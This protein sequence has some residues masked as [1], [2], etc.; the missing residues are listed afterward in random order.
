MRAHT[1]E[2]SALSGMI[3]S[4]IIGG[5]PAYAECGGLMYLA[6]DMVQGGHTYRMAGVFDLGTRMAGRLILNYTSGVT[7]RSPVSRGRAGFRGHEFRYSKATDISGDAVFAQRLDTGDGIAGGQDGIISHNAMASYG[8]LY[9]SRAGA[10]ALADGCVRHS[11][12]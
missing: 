5:M 6:R 8:H 9:L 10:R 1:L 4:A 3:R 2:R 7:C 11:R 12:S